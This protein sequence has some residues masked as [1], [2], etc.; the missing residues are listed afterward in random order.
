EQFQKSYQ[1]SHQTH[2][3]YS[4]G[5]VDGIVGKG[6]LLALDEALMDGWVYSF[7]SDFEWI[8]TPLIQLIM[9]KESRG[10]YNAYNISGWTKDGNNKVFESHFSPTDSFF[11]E[12]MTIE[13]IKKSQV[14]T[15][16]LGKETKALFA[17]GAYQLIPA[18]LNSAVSW[19]KSKAAIDESTQ[20]FNKE[21]QD[22]LPF[23]FFEEKRKRVGNYF[24]GKE[25][26]DN[27]AYDIAQEWASAGV[28]KGYK[29]NNGDISDGTKSYYFGDGLNKAHYSAEMTVSSL[30]KTKAII[31]K[32]GG[33]D[34]ILNAGLEKITKVF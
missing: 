28:P 12:E 22:L 3:S 2:P 23:Y 33:Y 30:E 8:K 21:F 16:I 4:I 5:P 26:V 7:N 15:R 20:K 18:T 31:D 13:D 11:I 10:S 19:I 27:A 14:K 25:S 34:Y 32:N 6:T 9:S 29:I 17:V 24:R 1:P